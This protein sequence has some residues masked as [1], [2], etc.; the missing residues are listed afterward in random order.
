MSMSITSPVIK[1]IRPVIHDIGV[2]KIE[3]INGVVLLSL[4]LIITG[5]L[6]NPVIEWS[7]VSD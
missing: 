6:E 4:Y 2:D 3:P 7:R 1:M 5:I